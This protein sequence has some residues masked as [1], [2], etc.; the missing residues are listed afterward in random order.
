MQQVIDSN[1]LQHEPHVGHVRCVQRVE[2][3]LIK[4]VDAEEKN[5]FDLNRHSK[6]DED[7]SVKP[8]TRGTPAIFSSIPIPVDSSC[9]HATQYEKDMDWTGS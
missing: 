7:F 8:G 2:R 4:V 1:G 9:T 3:L 5:Q 6:I